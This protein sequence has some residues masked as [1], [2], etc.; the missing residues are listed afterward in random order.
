MRAAV[1]DCNANWPRHGGFVLGEIDGPRRFQSGDGQIMRHVL[2]DDDYRE[3]AL[4]AMARSVRRNAGDRVGA[5]W[6]NRTRKRRAR[7]GQAGAVIRSRGYR[8]IHHTRSLSEIHNDFD[9]GWTDNLRKLGVLYR[10]GEQASDRAVGPAVDG[11]GPDEEEGA[12]GRHAQHSATKAT[13]CRCQ[14]RDNR[15]TLAQIGRDANI[16]KT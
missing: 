13:G 11:R 5:Q 16:R 10:D 9:V 3:S 8:I 6:E 7:Y 2:R 4:V 15:S 14:V 1:L 12:G